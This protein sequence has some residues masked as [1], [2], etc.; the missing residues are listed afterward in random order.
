MTITLLFLSI[1]LILG[2]FISFIL[3]LLFPLLLT[4]RIKYE[5]EFLEKELQGYT[6]YKKKVK[7]KMIPFIW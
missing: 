7:Y 2:S 6:E 4:K 1:P 3:F 5:E